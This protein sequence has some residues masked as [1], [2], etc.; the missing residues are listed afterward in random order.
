MIQHA[1]I[2]NLR[3]LA[4]C[5][6]LL[7]VYAFASTADAQILTDRGDNPEINSMFYDMVKAFELAKSDS[8]ITREME[9]KEAVLHFA[10]ATPAFRP[11][12]DSAGC[13]VALRFVPFPLPFSIE[14]GT[15]V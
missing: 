11:G 9:Q 15:N 5:L 13:F 7:A 1:I 12:W 4:T 10:R 6:T 8:L 2:K 14:S 3:P